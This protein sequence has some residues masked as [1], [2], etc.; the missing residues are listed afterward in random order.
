MS[1]NTKVSELD[2]IDNNLYDND[3][4]LISRTN[5]S[6]KKSFKVTTNNISEFVKNAIKPEINDTLSSYVKSVNG[7]TPDT[8]GNVQ[9]NSVNEA[10]SANK[11]KTSR[12]ISLTGDVSGNVNFDGN[13]DV[14]LNTTLNKNNIIKDLSSN[15]T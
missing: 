2:S 6:I 10:T 7:S 11:L 4:F 9:I 15:K 5:D 1:Q 3:V 14:T 12:K 8:T 13:S